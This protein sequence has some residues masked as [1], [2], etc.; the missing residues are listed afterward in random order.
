MKRFLSMNNEP[1]NKKLLYS[2]LL[3]L[4]VFGYIMKYTMN[5][6]LSRHLST[7]SYG[8]FSIA[9]KILALTSALALLGTNS[10][11]V[12]FISSYLKEKKTL[13]LKSF[14]EWNVKLIR[15]SFFVCILIGVVSVG[16]MHL[17]HWW[18]WKHIATYHLSIYMLW[19]TPV[20]S[21]FIL[22]GSYLLCA[23]HYVLK[24]FLENSKPI[25]TILL[26]FLLIFIMEMPVND[27]TLG[28]ILLLSYVIFIVIELIFIV[29]K[30]PIVGKFFLDALSLKNDATLTQ[31]WFQVSCRLAFNGVLCAFIFSSDLILIQLLDPVREN[32]SLYAVALTIASCLFVIPQNIYTFIKAQVSS[33]VTTVEGKKDLEQSIKYLNRISYSIT[34]VLASSLIIFAQQLL[35]HFGTFYQQAEQALIILTVGFS[36]GSTCQ[37]ATAVMAYSGNETFLLKITITELIL[38]IVL[39]ILAT[40]IWGYIGAAYATS[41]TIIIKALLFHTSSYRQVGVKTYT[42]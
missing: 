39:T 35:A 9:L 37:P 2:Y 42:I 30:I 10:S 1:I 8:D 13:R 36:I 16:I 4:A 12:R 34:L 15:Y 26:F 5:I 33:L 38:M 7:V 22:L 3:L 19:V 23:Q 11:T 6:V 17:L 25:L 40:Y 29:F 31:D 18:Q 24:A 27:F 20:A 21:T 41:I 14:I 28:L 32:V